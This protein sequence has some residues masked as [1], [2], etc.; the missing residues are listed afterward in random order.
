MRVQQLIVG[1]IYPRVSENV[2]QN[3]AAFYTSKI[4][5]RRHK[6]PSCVRA[7]SVRLVIVVPQYFVTFEFIMSDI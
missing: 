3:G 5:K 1:M 2:P 4:R 7:P 6:H